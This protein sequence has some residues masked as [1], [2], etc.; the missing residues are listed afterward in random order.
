MSPP[1]GPG[2]AALASGGVEVAAGERRPPIGDQVLGAFQIVGPGISHDEA[3]GFPD[4]LELAVFLDLA[5]Q[6]RLGDVVVRHHGGIAAGQVRHGDTDNRVDHGIRIGGAGFFDRFDPHVEADEMCFHRVVG[7]A[8]VVADKGLPGFNELGIGVGVRG[9]EV[10]PGGKVADQRSGVE[11]G[12]FFFAH[13]EGDN[14]NVFGLDAGIA[15]FLV[16]RHVGIAVDRGDNSG[17]LACGTEGLDVGND[18]LP[19]GMSERRVVDHDVFFSNTLGLQIGFQDLVGRARIDIVGAGQDPA[20]D[21]FLV[22]QV[23]D[24]RDGL[25]VRR[26]AGV[27]DVALAFFTFVLDR[28]EQQRIQFFKDRQNGLARHGSPAAEDGIDAIDFDQLTRLF[29]KERPV[30]GRV[31]DDGFQFLAKQAALFVLLFDEHQHGV[32]ERG[33]GNRHRAGQ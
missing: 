20:L 13:G 3:G 22:H 31:D 19:V 14:R 18:R 7:H 12:E 17:L 5:D 21:A 9:L 2:A 32:F 29:G 28:I 25:L 1:L 10:V 8:L 24:G 16:E 26:G 30:R 4:G 27:E 6:H 11:T 33:F 23:I 15:E